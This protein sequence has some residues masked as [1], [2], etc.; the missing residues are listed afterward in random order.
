MNK[1]TYGNIA[2]KYDAFPELLIPF[3]S[4]PVTAVQQTSK[5]KANFQ[6]GDP[7]PSSMF[8]RIFITVFL[9]RFVI[10]TNYILPYTPSLREIQ[11]RRRNNTSVALPRVNLSN[12][13]RI[14]AIR[15]L[16]LTLTPWQRN[17][18]RV[19]EVSHRQGQDRR[20]IANDRE[21]RYGLSNS[22]ASHQWTHVVHLDTS[23]AGKLSDHHLQIVQWPSHHEQYNQIRND[24]GSTPV[25]QGCVRKSPYISESNRK[26]Y[27]RQQ[28]LDLLAPLFAQL[29]IFWGGFFQT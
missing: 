16:P 3:T 1:I 5:H 21:H 29:F 22:D 9:K 13:T 7:I 15:P 12:E 14:Y 10:T 23:S 8:G 25:L 26:R 27:T 6:S 24:E 17:P 2:K 20:I 4:S 11:L 28:E 18:K 19:Y